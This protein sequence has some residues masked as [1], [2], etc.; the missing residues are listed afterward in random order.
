MPTT[1]HVTHRRTDQPQGIHRRTVFT[2]DGPTASRFWAKVDKTPGH[3]P[4]GDC[5][6]WTG[7]DRGNGYGVLK[8]H[9]KLISAHVL[10]FAIH[11]NLPTDG[12]IVCHSCDVRNCVNPAHLMADTPKAN[13]HDAIDKGRM[14]VGDKTHFAKLTE[15][16]VRK[17]RA[18]HS[19]GASR[20]KISARFPQVSMRTIEQILKRETWKHVA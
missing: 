19:A 18:L 1:N 20:E 14:L 9:G 5:W 7:T 6:L 3:G 10:S 13:A 17:M 11:N 2:V 15:R 4:N 8:V 12:L 16:D